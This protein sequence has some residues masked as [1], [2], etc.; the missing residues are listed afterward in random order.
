MPAPVERK[1]FLFVVGLVHWE[2]NRPDIPPNKYYYR[3]NTP[4]IDVEIT[5]YALLSY[6]AYYEVSDAI[7]NSSPIV[8]WLV[9]Q[10]N[11]RGGFSSTQVT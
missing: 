2:S 8:R 4:S 10:Q 6:L 3:Y 9:Q 1:L 5:A 7:V 11:P